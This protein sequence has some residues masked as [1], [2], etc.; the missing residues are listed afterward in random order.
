MLDRLRDWAGPFVLAVAILVGGAAGVSPVFQNAAYAQSSVRPPENAALP[1]IIQKQPSDA[2][3][4]RAIRRGVQGYVSIPDKQAGVMIQSGGEQWRNIRNGLV[5]PYSGWVLA[6]V[7]GLLAIFFA[8]RGRIQI[9][10]GFSGRTIER[11]SPLERYAH[12]LLASTFIVLAITGLNVLFGRFLFLAEPYVG[13][14]ISPGQETYAWLTRVGKVLHNM[15][16]WAFMVGLVLA[17]VLWLRHNLPDRY[18]FI[19]LLKG[20]GMFSPGVHPPARKFNA[21]QKILFW[22]VI[23][24]GVALSVSGLFLL[25]PFAWTDMAGMQLSQLIHAIVAVLM[26]AVIIGHIYLGTVGMQ[27]AF[28]AM[29]TGQVDEN[30]A[31]EHHSVWVAEI[32]GEQPPKAESGGGEGHVQPAE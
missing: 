25:F 11:F 3:N 9:D 23:L 6:A 20:G 19:W 16:A 7:V 28:D 26:V 4:W 22:L 21:G 27:G 24:G 5:V 18:D 17:F 15:G 14:G 10:S 29:W 32:K 2:D 8:A 30:W 1:V 13:A 12:W 31:R